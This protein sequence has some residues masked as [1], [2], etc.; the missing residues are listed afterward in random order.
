MVDCVEYLNLP[1]KA[2]ILLVILF[3]I[4]QIIGEILEVKGL[5][6]P[7]FIKL[8]KYFARKKQERR[9]L[10]EV[11][12]ALMAVQKQLSDIHDWRKEFDRKLDKS[13]AT[14]MSLMIE[15]K[16]SEIIDFASYVIDTENPVT[17]EQFNR[18]FRMY[19]DYETI[20][21]ENHLSNGEARIAMRI[22]HESY[23]THMREHTFVEDVRGYEH[24]F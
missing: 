12:T 9:T 23:E 7:E 17:R 10:T 21:K 3:L 20:L 18:I 6:V 19:D 13:N 2:A 4:L 14:V 24:S 15:D 1:A 22:I 5:A 16:R 8:R 11:K